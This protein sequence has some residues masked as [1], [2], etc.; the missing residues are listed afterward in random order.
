M[1][2]FVQDALNS[3]IDAFLG[4][5]EHGHHVS[6]FCA[7]PG[8][9]DHCAVETAFRAEDTWS[10]NEDNLAVVFDGNAAYD[11]AGCLHL[12]SD[13]RDFCANQ[14]VQQRRLARIWRANQRDKA[15]A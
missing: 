14:L 1:L 15:S 10:V 8:C 11:C 2:Q 13:N 3:F 4:I 9:V 5:D 7:A 6:V 12:V